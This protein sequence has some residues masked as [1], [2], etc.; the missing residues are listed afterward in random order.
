MSGSLF[1]EA[2]AAFKAVLAREMGCS[3]EAYGSHALTVVE[4]PPGS[5]E[6]HLALATTCGTGSV[7]SVRDP[8]LAAWALQQDLPR[9]YRIFLPSFLEGL[10]ARAGEL[11]HAN[12]KS[13]SATTGMILA[14][15]HGPPALP[16]TYSL[17]QLS[18][19]EQA[20]LRAG[21]VFDNALLEP[22]ERK[23]ERFRTAFAAFGRDGEVAAVAGV[24][25]QYPGID[26]IGL[27]VARE[28]RG[29]GLGRAMAIHAARWIREQG[30]WPIYTYGFTNIRSANTGLAAGFRP[31]WQ[32]AAVYR[33]EDVE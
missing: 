17:R 16:A 3:V 33:P 1:R 27:D 14:E 20:E 21:E 23:V 4:R 28:R 24:W 29:L 10:A 22:G 26:E 8:R 31:L 18:E 11:G 30:R 9:H 12:P 15:L 7:L 19:R 25:D 32:I 13:H 5:R 2:A 6:P